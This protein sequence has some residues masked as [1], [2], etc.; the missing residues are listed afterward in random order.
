MVEF[1]LQR[2]MKTIYK[3]LLAVV[4]AAIVTAC[5]Y[6]DLDPTDKVGSGDIF[7]STTALEKAVTGAYSQMSLRTTI[8]V[9]SVLSDDV[10][11][12]GQNGGAGDDSY[13][14]TYSVGTG[15]HNNLWSRY[16]SVINMVNRIL[17]GAE[18]VPATTE[19]E[20][21]SKNNSIGTALFMR[22]YV[23]FD[24]LRYFSDF[25]QGDGYG[26]PYV[27]KPVILET[28]GRNTVA[29]S[30]E[31]MLKDLEE[32]Q[33]LLSQDT[34]GNPAYV[35]KTA[36][37]AL[38]A[39]ICLYQRQYSRAYDLAGQVLNEKPLAGRE[40]YTGIW[41]DE[42]NDD[43]IF[44]LKKLPGEERIGTIYFSEDNS[45]A[46]EPSTELINSYEEGDIRL[47]T[48]IGDGVDR[49]GVKVKRVNKYKGTPEN[50]GLADQKLLRSSEMILIMAEA[51]AHTDLDAANSLLNRLRAARIEGW[52]EQ[53][54]STREE[55][56][57]QILLERRRELCFEGHR[58]FDM[59]RFER[60]IYKPQ[61]DK[62]LAVDNYRRVQPIPLAELQGNPV[63]AKQQNSGY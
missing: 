18:N 42:S 62:T 50:V 3:S 31:L 8:Q 5:D 34:P 40:N 47:T 39:R 1:Q 20:K 22:A 53:K 9:S 15:D 56:L 41:S 58:F 33:P 49:E 36:A 48:F 54:Y 24:L 28:P 13:Q 44:K 60:P 29:E 51:K 32:C 30:F 2:K 17:L 46:F 4:L 25:E 19:A 59:R 57:N 10:Y 21:Q 26:I 63:I 16:Y 14:W 37:K 35:S 43:V 55:M 6:T 23:S 11:K 12:G 27:L 61:I 45:S 52:A 38:M 7:S